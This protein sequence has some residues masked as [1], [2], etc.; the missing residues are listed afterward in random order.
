MKDVARSA[1]KRGRELKAAAV[2]ARHPVGPHVAGDR[3]A[4]E[5]RALRPAPDDGLLRARAGRPAGRSSPGSRAP[6]SSWPTTPATWTRRSS[7]P[8]CRGACARGP[9]W[10]PRPTTSTRTASSPRPSRSSSTRCR[11]SAAGAGMGKNGSGHLDKL[12]DQGWNL[13]LFPEGTRTRDGGP[14]RV[15]RGAAVLA[16]AHNLS[17]VPIRVTGT[18]AAMPPG[19]LWPKRLHGKVFSRAP[20]HQ[21]V[22][23]RADPP[24]RGHHGAHRARAELLRQRRRRPVALAVPSQ[25]ARRHSLRATSIGGRRP[26]APNLR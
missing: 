14:G 12:L 26:S 15:R 1:P 19:R 10:P 9:R 6:S 17:I 3:D 7:W 16:A 2:A 5:L 25:E 21:R 11:S 20:S 24:M 13:L 8:R 22:L 23:R 4:R 18:R